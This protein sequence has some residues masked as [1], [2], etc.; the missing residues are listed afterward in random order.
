M[1]TSISFKKIYRKLLI[2]SMKNLR[3][4]SIVITGDFNFWSSQWW[5]G[6][7][8]LPEGIVLDRLFESNNLAQLID[9]P[10]N[11]EPRGIFCV[12]L[13][14]TDQPNLSVDYGIHSSPDDCCHHQIIHGKLND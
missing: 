12:D 8:N 9:Q 10:T 6:D 2:A 4:H 14:A 7:R 5:P 3:P 13:I 1:K 11:I